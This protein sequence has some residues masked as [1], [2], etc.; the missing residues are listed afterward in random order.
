MNSANGALCLFLACS[1]LCITA[2]ADRSP[3]EVGVT[4]T[5]DRSVN[6]VRQRDLVLINEVLCASVLALHP[7]SKL[8]RLMRQVIPGVGALNIVR[9]VM[10]C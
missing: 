3:R 1:K 10:S 8:T 7:E 4:G 9:P 2:E 6:D 5:S